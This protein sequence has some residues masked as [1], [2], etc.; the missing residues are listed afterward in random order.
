MS[1]RSPPLATPHLTPPPRASAPAP[2]P[3]PTTT[4]TTIPTRQH[5]PPPAPPTSQIIPILPT[6]FARIYS[7]THPFLILSL[8]YFSF[9]SIVENPV[10][11]LQSLLVPLSFLQL[12]YVVTC[13]PTI[14]TTNTPPSSGSGGGNS[15][16]EALA[17]HFPPLVANLKKSSSSSK[18]KGKG[19]RVEQQNGFNLSG[20][21]VVSTFIYL[22][23]Y[24][25]LSL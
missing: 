15:S 10:L 1:R 21:L 13:L 4:T 2:A 8:Y 16:G 18:K 25:S 6:E 20:K 11:A 14:T 12:A 9:A 17:S 24:I 7:I 22:S 23:I 19:K 5:G 3:T